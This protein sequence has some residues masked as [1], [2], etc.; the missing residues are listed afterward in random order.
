MPTIL[1]AQTM[2]S[3]SLLT[4][5]GILVLITGLY[6]VLDS[7]PGSSAT[8]SLPGASS[9]SWSC[10]GSPTASSFP[11]T[12]ARCA[13]HGATSRAPGR[14]AKSNS[15]RSSTNTRAAMPE[16]ADRRPDRDPHHLRD[17]GQA[18]PVGVDGRVCG[19]LAPES[20]PRRACGGR[21][22]RS[23]AQCAA[24][25]LRPPP[26]T[27]PASN[28]ACGCSEP[29]TRPARRAH[30]RGARRRGGG[31]ADKGEPTENADAID[32]TEPTE[33][34]EPTEPIDRN[35]PFEQ[36]DR[37]ESHDHGESQESPD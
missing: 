32:P 13:R 20:H 29:I 19:A 36:I 25:R 30:H 4:I 3:R 11:T 27:A 35:D 28:R 2:I 6:L 34:A 37:A 1:E 5:G 16:W 33:S 31:R 7:R 8:S 24:P 22:R 10:W 12:S 26:S 21:A 9:R 14:P 18:V 23:G 15:A 17:G